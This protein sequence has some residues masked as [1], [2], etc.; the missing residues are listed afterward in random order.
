MVFFGS[1]VH[2]VEVT[3]LPQIQSQGGIA[4][5]PRRR[6]SHEHFIWDQR[7][8][9]NPEFTNHYVEHDLQVK[10]SVLIPI[11][12]MFWSGGKMVQKNSDFTKLSESGIL[13]EN[14][15]L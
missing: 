4:N 15:I 11:L 13:L 14:Q 3:N 10:R 7:T 2:S 5:L 1:Q 8:N 9:A 12:N 6:T